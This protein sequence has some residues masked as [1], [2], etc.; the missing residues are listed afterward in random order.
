MR[1][2]DKTTPNPQSA[3]KR[4]S[5]AFTLVE[6]LCVIALA[7]LVAAAVA[8]A[9]SSAAAAYRRETFSS[10]AQVLADAARQALGESFH[11]MTISTGDTP[12]YTVE[13]DQE[14]LSGT[15]PAELIAQEGRLYLKQNDATIRLLN[16]GV[17]G[18]LQ[19]TQ[20]RSSFA[21]DMVE[22]SFTVEDSAGESLSQTF[23]FEFRRLDGIVRQKDEKKQQDQD[24]TDRSSIEGGRIMPTDTEKQ[25]VETLTDAWNLDRMQ[26]VKLSDPDGNVY[27]ALE[28]PWGEQYAMVYYRHRYYCI[29]QG[30]DEDAKQESTPL[31][32]SGGYALL[33]SDLT[34][35]AEHNY[36]WGGG[37]VWKQ[38]A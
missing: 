10:Q 16:D 6:T 26:W 18:S 28:F 7:A 34:D 35:G 25:L 4:L 14:K 1:R 5:S 19:V 27:Y 38:V 20:A 11:Y 30:K 33:V 15:E 13:L 2:E 22:G 12:T 23:T 36:G 17:Y 3:R 8:L 24:N 37:H 9:T 29:Y 31:P 21:N 32:I